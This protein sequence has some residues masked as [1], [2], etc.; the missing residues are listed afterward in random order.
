MTQIDNTTQEI[1]K[2]FKQLSTRVQIHFWWIDTKVSMYRFFNIDHSKVLGFPM[3]R[4]NF[5]K[6]QKIGEVRYFECDSFQVCRHLDGKSPHLPDDNG[7]MT[8]QR[9]SGNGFKCSQ[10]SKACLH[11][12]KR[13]PF[14]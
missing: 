4:K 10:V 5:K 13:A 8:C 11:D 14:L 3:T 2:L 12:D 9:D 1:L 6:W 7:Y